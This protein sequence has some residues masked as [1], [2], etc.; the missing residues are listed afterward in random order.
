MTLNDLSESAVTFLL[1]DVEGSTALWERDHKAMETALLRYD[2]ILRNAIGDHVGYVFKVVGDA[3]HAS[4]ASP[5]E[6]LR[7]ALAAQR[8]LRVGLREDY[9]DLKVRTALHTGESERRGNDY[10]GLSLNRAHRLLLA[11]YGGQVLISGTTRDLVRDE[12][13]PGAELRYLGKRR[14]RD[15]SHP[16]RVFR[17]AAPDLPTS[18]P[19]LRTLDA[20]HHNLPVQPT[21]FVGREREVKASGNLLR[22]GHTRL[23]TL[24]GT[25]G[26][27]K[28]RLGLR[29]AT[30][31][32]DELEEGVCFVALAGIKEPTLVAPAIANALGIVKTTEQPPLERLT[33]YLRTREL[34]L[35]LDNFEHIVEAGSLVSE[36]LRT[37]PQLKVLVTSREEL[38]LNGEYVF[39]VPPLSMP[40]PNG[41]QDMK[42]LA[43]C[44]SVDLFVARARAVKFGFALSPEISSTVAGI[45][46]RLEGLP[47]AM[48][49]FSTG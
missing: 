47:L 9:C 20:R 12:L 35:V 15:L 5:H 40:T 10:F 7:C 33:E 41:S 46:V 31:L 25:G 16:Q 1:V 13:P 4:F 22:K 32:V 3:F 34:L 43:E 19:P 2:D 26:T 6:A 37:A 29:V 23:L 11:G 39:L 24:T 38:R 48:R 49:T 17:L 44:E 27:G 14:L 28:T 36:L 30:D 21:A 8:A 18:L 42:A 45:C